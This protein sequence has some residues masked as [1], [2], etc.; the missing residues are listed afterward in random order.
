MFKNIKVGDFVIA[1]TWSGSFN[2]MHKYVL[3]VVT[4]VNKKT[5]KVDRYQHRTFTIDNGSVYGGDFFDRIIIMKY[6][7]EFYEK[8]VLEQKQEELRINLLNKAET[9][10]YTQLTTEQLER[11]FAI[12]EETQTQEG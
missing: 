5:F 7:A 4:K 12:A 9:F 10:D 3:C 11:M 1:H 8:K 2:P 6:D